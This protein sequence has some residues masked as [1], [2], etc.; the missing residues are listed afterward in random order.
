MSQSIRKMLAAMSVATALL[1]MV[2]APS[3]AAQAR[4][5]APEHTLGLMAQ[6]WSWVESLLGDPRP[7]QSA[8]RKD[9]MPPPPPL[10]PP[11]GQGP[12]IDPDGAR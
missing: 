4:K 10:P 9:V 6:V 12:A 8:P 7:Q 2:P 11:P 1:L 5:P 3:W